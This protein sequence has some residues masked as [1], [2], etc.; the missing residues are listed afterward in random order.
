MTFKR[1]ESVL[2]VIYTMGGEVLCLRRADPPDFW[3]SVTGSLLWQETA[4]E[5]AAREVREETGLEPDFELLDTGI[6]N[7][8]PIHPAWR[9][10]YAPEVHHNLEHVF[11][12]RLPEPRPVALEPA[13]HAEYRWLPREQAAALVSSDTD[14]EAILALVPAA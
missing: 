5:A 2:V 14:R 6:V 7:R 13:E 4:P 11:C 12:L 8:Y 10:R 9:E 1:P 3:Q